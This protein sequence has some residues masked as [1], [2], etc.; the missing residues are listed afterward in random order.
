LSDGA[1]EP[2][3]PRINIAATIKRFMLPSKFQERL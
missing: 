1:K 2:A 3:A